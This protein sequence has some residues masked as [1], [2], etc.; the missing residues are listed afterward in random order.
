MKNLTQE[1]QDLVKEM[2][3]SNKARSK[4]TSQESW[5]EADALPSGP[6]AHMSGGGVVDGD[7]AGQG[8]EYHQHQHHQVW[9]RRQ[10]QGAENRKQNKALGSRL[11][12]SLKQGK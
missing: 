2:K 11:I 4:Q 1:E 5:F 12:T 10:E 6:M 3:N 8:A 9:D 7:Y